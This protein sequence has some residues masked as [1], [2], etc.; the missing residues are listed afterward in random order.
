MIA[1]IINA[2]AVIIGSLLGMLGRRWI[3]PPIKD[4][5]MLG[6]GVFT[7]VI[8][9]DMAIESQR[10]LYLALSLVL[11]GVTGTL[12]KLEDRLY[13]IGEW[14]K[15]RGVSKNERFS[16]GFL[17]ASVLFCVG[18]MSILGALEAGAQGSYEILLTKSV[19]DGS[20]AILLAAAMGFGVA[21]SAVTIISYQGLLTLLAGT[22]SPFLNE[23]MLSE[24]SAVG[25]ALIVMIGLTLSGLKKVETG[26]FLPALFF[27][28]GFAA[29]DPLYML[30]ST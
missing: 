30:F 7:L 27:A 14:V 24:L 1:T 26:N 19:L 20:M 29:W 3:T 10:F 6:V 21:L 17:T 9:M 22:I 15:H 25:G 23:L 18:A 5:I 2:A 13:S 8:G 4:T 16:E 28:V 12:L 11:G